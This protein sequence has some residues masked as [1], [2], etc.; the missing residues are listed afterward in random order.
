M[1]DLMQPEPQPFRGFLLRL[2]HLHNL[3]HI[4]GAFISMEAR[5]GIV[6]PHAGVNG[7]MGQ[8]VQQFPQQPFRQPALVPNL[9]AIREVVQELYGPGLRKIDHLEFYKPYPEM[10]NSEN[11]YLRGYRI[12][13]FSLFFGEYSQSTLEHVARFTVQWE[14]LANH[15]NFYHFKLRLYPNS[16]TREAFTWYTKLPRNSIRSW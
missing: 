4:K 7:N 8:Q 15:E 12:L 1:K 3:E 13:D 16:L 5:G 11:P 14:E 6:Q 2:I 10:I 9:G